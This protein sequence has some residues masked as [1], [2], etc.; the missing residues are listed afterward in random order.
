MESKFDEEEERKTQKRMREAEVSHGSYIHHQVSPSGL[1]GLVWL[2]QM[3]FPW[4]TTVEAH[5]SKH[6]LCEW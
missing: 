3:T 6:L 2:L 1:P 4:M 5:W